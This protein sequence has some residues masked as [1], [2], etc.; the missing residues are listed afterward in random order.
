MDRTATIGLTRRKDSQRS[1]TTMPS[2]P[3]LID[4][5]DI[6]GVHRT[7]TIDEIGAVYDA[8][9]RQYIQIGTARGT[10]TRSWR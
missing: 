7:A 1:L 10:R 3:R 5:F 2:G 6:P 9:L 8:R 4:Y